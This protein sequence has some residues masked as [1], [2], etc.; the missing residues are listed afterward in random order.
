MPHT[1]LVS[2]PPLARVTSRLRVSC[3]VYIIAHKSGDTGGS[4]GMEVAVVVTTAPELPRP[5][6]NVNVLVNHVSPRTH[7]ERGGALSGEK[8]ASFSPPNGSLAGV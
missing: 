3:R 6:Y 4:G 2:S 5:V 1:G 7:N 8:Y